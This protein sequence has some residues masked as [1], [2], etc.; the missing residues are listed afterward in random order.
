MPWTDTEGDM[1]YNSD[2]I[3]KHK[4]RINVDIGGEAHM[5]Q[6]L[7]GSLQ[8]IMGP[9]IAPFRWNPVQSINH[10]YIYQMLLESQKNP[11]NSYFNGISPI[12]IIYSSNL[13]ADFPQFHLA[14]RP[15]SSW[16]YGFARAFRTRHQLW[17]S[18]APASHQVRVSTVKIRE[19]PTKKAWISGKLP[20]KTDEFLM[21]FSSCF[22]LVG[23]YQIESGKPWDQHEL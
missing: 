19:A 15:R 7:T 1:N 3:S 20:G 16:S 14:G 18:C 4:D 8:C 21:F 17:G 10:I 23:F 5:S 9:Y 22:F 11:F 13:S 2:Q 6:P 12:S